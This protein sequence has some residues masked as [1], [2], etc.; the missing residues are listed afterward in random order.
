M[1]AALIL[2][3]LVPW[4]FGDSA[5]SM[6]RLGPSVAVAAEVV[7]PRPP[8][9]VEKVDVEPRAQLVAFAPQGERVPV[10]EALR[11][12]ISEPVK[13][14]EL[15]VT[16]DPPTPTRRRWLTP[17]V[18]N[19]EPLSNWRQGRAHR[20]SVGVAG[21]PHVEL[22]FRT[23]VP[24]PF[25]ITPG[26][27]KRAILTFDDGPHR[28]R[29]ADQILDML[30]KHDAKAIFFPT[31]KWARAR[32]DWVERAVKEGHWVCNHTYSHRNLT[33]PPITEAMIEFEI[34]NGAGDGHC[35][36]F[37]PPL[38]AVDARVERIVARL[39]YRMFLWDVDSRDWEDTPAP[40]VEN[41]VLGQ[42]KP[43][44][45]VLLHIHAEGTHQAL[46]RIL[47]RLIDAG[48]R[49][50]FAPRDASDVGEGRIGL[51]QLPI[52]SPALL[53]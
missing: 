10:G 20:V 48:Y 11:I 22:T 35:K 21:R 51:G 12:E 39:G 45:V 4:S 2:I 18:L 36:L 17:R 6:A 9:G 23:L 5:P 7:S 53:D 42:I 28:R 29:Q 47:E 27:D 38:M 43:D 16:V 52:P 37:R 15:Q 19:V 49:P 13:D 46:P 34:L 8:R 50:T 31:G 26:E 30:A 24:E 32:P 1:R 14:G 44:D 25:V 40:D 41:R 3:A 33:K